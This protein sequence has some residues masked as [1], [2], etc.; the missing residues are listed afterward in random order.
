MTARA[1]QAADDRDPA[2]LLGRIDARLAVT[3]RDAGRPWIVGVSGGP[4]SVCMA[5]AVRR[6]QPRRK[7]ILAHVDHQLQ[8]ESAQ[9]ADLVVALGRTLATEVRVVQ[10]DV[11]GHARRRRVGIELAARERRYAALA[12]I[13]H[14]VGA[15]TVLTGH[16]RDDHVESILMHLLR[17]AGVDGLIGIRVRQQLSGFAGLSGTTGLLL[18]P[19]L[20]VTRAET[21]GY[22]DERGLAWF[23]DATNL[24]PSFDRNR[25][26]MHLLPLLRTY[27]PRFDDAL[28]RLAELVGDEAA[29]VGR[30]AERSATRVVCAPIDSTS[31]RLRRSA[32]LRAP[33][34]LARRIVRNALTRVTGSSQELP[35]AL[36][37][38]VMALARAG[39]SRPRRLTGGL[40]VHCDAESITIRA[41]TADCPT[42]DHEPGSEPLAR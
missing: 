25:V 31:V 5:H 38:Q 26:R 23:S 1:R 27:N 13:A 7:L 40:V 37:D 32:L 29:V 17:G 20:D 21:R 3:P 4:D 8:P 28:V 18:R 42:R 34:A 39:A 15:R 35:M 14:S 6:L 19:L 11:A 2:S 12:D 22:C 41:E 30:A 10:E 33:R 9:A 16:T 24:D 36:T